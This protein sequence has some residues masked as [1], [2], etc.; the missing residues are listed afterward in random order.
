MHMQNVIQYC[1]RSNVLISC[2]APFVS[3]QM[4]IYEVCN[5]S[6]IMYYTNNTHFGCQWLWD[7]Y[8]EYICEDTQT[9]DNTN[10]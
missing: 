6:M 8:S 7:V 5:I 9:I 1:S 3:K 2:L 4:M 10:V